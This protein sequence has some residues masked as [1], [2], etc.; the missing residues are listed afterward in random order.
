MTLDWETLPPVRRVDML[1]NHDLAK[2]EREKLELLRT[3]LDYFRPAC[4]ETR[5]DVLR[6]EVERMRRA[7]EETQS[8]WHRAQFDPPTEVVRLPR[9]G[10]VRLPLGNRNFVT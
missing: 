1:T 9:H 10:L 6:G 5:V 2:R 3:M 8:R 4:R 7:T